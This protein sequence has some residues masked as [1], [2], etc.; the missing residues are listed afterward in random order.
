[1]GEPIEYGGPATCSKCGSIASHYQ[2]HQHLCPKHYRFG[3]MRANAKRRGKS[4][5]S[6]EDLEALLDAHMKC[7]DCGVSMNWLARDGQST[8]ISLQH[9]RS[10]ALGL[11]CRS[12]NT[13]HAYTPGDT[14]RSLPMDH[15]WCPRCKTSK[16]DTEFSHD[17]G[18]SGPRKIKS[19]CRACSAKAHS[20]WTSKNKDHVNAKQRERRARRSAG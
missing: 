15:K 7:A 17:R 12:C 8:V 10:G 18:R 16:S 5:P 14:Y 13:R 19:W 20:E 4:V 2:G 11:V 3:Q 6:H 1:M 9:Y